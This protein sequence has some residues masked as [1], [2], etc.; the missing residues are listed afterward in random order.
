MS[1]LNKNLLLLTKIENRQFLSKEELDFKR[2]VK[3]KV[4]EFSPLINSKSVK[5][6]FKTD[7]IFKVKISFELAE[8]LV[9]NLL[10]NAIKHNSINGKIHIELSTTEL[11]ICNTGKA[12]KLTSE[13][14][15]NRYIK[16][17]SQSYGL[18]LAIVKQICDTHNIG[19]D[20][21]KSD[22]HCFVLSKRPEL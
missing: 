15:F 19:L 11:R 6:D 12:N 21:Q 9:N 8:I 17:N 1:D 22:V 2:I 13:T 18:G 14:I 7:G 10:T 16:E 20:Y 3:N 4:E 5:I